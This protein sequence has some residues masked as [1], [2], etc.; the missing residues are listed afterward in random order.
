MLF[1]N[2]THDLR[3]MDCT[4]TYFFFFATQIRPHLPALVRL[5]RTWTLLYSLDQHGISLNTLYARCQPRIPS[6]SEPNPPK[7]AIVVVKDSL[8]GVFGAWV[9]EGIE[10]G[11]G[12]YY[13]TGEA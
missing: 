5:T 6:A 11:R 12:G 13:G 8:D 10:R 3:G 9:G 7:G 4:Y 2:G 1:W